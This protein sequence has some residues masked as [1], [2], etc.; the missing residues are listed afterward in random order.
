MV[1]SQFW[2][3]E[4]NLGDVTFLKLKKTYIKWRFTADAAEFLGFSYSIP[5]IKTAV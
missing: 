2:L 3:Q 4:D 1:N 5:F